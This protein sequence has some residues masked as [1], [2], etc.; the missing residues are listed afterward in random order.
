MARW[1][2]I[3]CWPCPL[4]LFKDSNNSIIDPW[5]SLPQ[6]GSNFIGLNTKLSETF[7]SRKSPSFSSSPWVWGV[8][9]DPIMSE[10]YISAGA[11]GLLSLPLDAIFESFIIVSKS[12]SCP[13]FCPSSL[14]QSSSSEASLLSL[15]SAL[16][17]SLPSSSP[18]SSSPN[19]VT[20]V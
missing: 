10:R 8:L 14:S 18:S 4:P 9:F 19:S 17:L 11:N 15:L 5:R 7:T 12:S 2:E 3:W 16:P 1:W 6:R 13:S 20:V